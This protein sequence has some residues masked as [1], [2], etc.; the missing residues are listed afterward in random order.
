MATRAERQSQG[1]RMAR[2]L[3]AAEKRLHRRCGQAHWHNLFGRT[4][5]LARQVPCLGSATSKRVA[6]RV[7]TRSSGGESPPEAAQA[8][9]RHAAAA[10]IL[11]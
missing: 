6:R 4:D 2:Q 8:C 7:C 9:T 11:T 1:A 3:P 10:E 5:L